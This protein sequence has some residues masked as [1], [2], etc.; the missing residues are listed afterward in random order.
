MNVTKV[1]KVIT[2]NMTSTNAK[3][4]P[5]AST[6]SVPMVELTISALANPNTVERIAP[7][8]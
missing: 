2:A 5:L 1:T 8:S 3:D 7:L 4:T 6:V